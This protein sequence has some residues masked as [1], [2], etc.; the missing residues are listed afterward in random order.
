MS[1]TVAGL[2][3]EILG[4]I[5]SRLLVPLTPRVRARAEGSEAAAESGASA[6]GASQARPAD[7]SQLLAGF[8]KNI[9][10]G[11]E[12]T[13]A[14]NGAIAQAAQRYG[15]DPNLI[16]AVIRQESGFN[17]EAVSKSGAMG[18]MQLMPATAESLGV[19]NPFDLNENIDGGAKYLQKQ[20]ARFGGD[21]SLALA[22]Y[23]AGPGSVEK[24]G[25]IPPYEETMDYVPKVL[26][27]REQ[28][29]LEQYAKNKTKSNT[30]LT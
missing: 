17:P 18:L 28:Y 29:I 2:Y 11:D 10:T 26:G 8:M 6:E 5:N 20:L 13:T 25:G 4:D 15:I 12:L 1:L 3:N 7:F 14:I 23:N 22:A 27:Y 16:K 21:E 9:P 30:I 24:Y 19:T